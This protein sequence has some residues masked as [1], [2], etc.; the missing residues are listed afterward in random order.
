MAGHE[1]EEEEE[2]EKEKDTRTVKYCIIESV[3]IVVG[4]LYSVKVIYG[5]D[6]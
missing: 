5:A 1:E 3:H 6:L 2:E 4:V